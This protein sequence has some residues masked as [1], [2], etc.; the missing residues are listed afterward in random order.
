VSVS[1]ATV[2]IG[3]ATSIETGLFGLNAADIAMNGGAVHLWRWHRGNLGRPDQAQLRGG[4]RDERS[5]A[6]PSEP[7]WRA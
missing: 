7:S 1:A 5:H 2:A 3:G 4:H 6:A